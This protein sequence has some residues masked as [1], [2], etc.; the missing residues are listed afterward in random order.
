[1]IFF[2]N[3]TIAHRDDVVERVKEEYRKPAGVAG[4][5]GLVDDASQDLSPVS[6][7][8]ACALTP[9]GPPERPDEARGRV[10]E[11][12]AEAGGLPP[13]TQ[14]A[15]E[16]LVPDPRSGVTPAEFV[17]R[18]LV[19]MLRGAPLPVSQ[20]CGNRFIGRARVNSRPRYFQ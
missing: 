11:S 19:A 18:K 20:I 9:V 8:P 17:E 16:T 7:P 4:P 13:R 5:G 15:D 1:M 14:P 3:R 6:D 10:Q 12:V 2:P